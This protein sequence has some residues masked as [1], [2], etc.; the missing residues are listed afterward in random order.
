MNGIMS[1]KL[2]GEQDSDKSLHNFTKRGTE[3]CGGLREG[4]VPEQKV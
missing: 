3:D 1:G 2:C 4:P